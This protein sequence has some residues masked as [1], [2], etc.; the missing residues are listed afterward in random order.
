MKDEDKLFIDSL[1]LNVDSIKEKMEKFSEMALQ[2]DENTLKIKLEVI[3]LHYSEI[4]EESYE[5]FKHLS[6]STLRFILKCWA[7]E[8][9]YFK[10]KHMLCSLS[11]L[12][13]M[14]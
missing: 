14:C 4:I 1:K 7:D 2:K 6:D 11:K 13:D 3:K 9:S 12:K 8:A 10:R 5:S